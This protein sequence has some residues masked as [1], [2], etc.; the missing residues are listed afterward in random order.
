M[1]IPSHFRCRLG[2]LGPLTM[3]LGT[4]NHQ[5]DTKRRGPI[6]NQTLGS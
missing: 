6:N 3:K 1:R 5:I 4:R 2:A